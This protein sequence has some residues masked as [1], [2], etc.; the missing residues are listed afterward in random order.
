L[1]GVPAGFADG[2]DNDTTY[3]AGTGLTLSGGQFSLDVPYR[4]PQSCANGQVPK[5]WNGLLWACATDNDTTYTAG[6]GLYLNATQFNLS[7]SYR[8]PQSCAN[9]QLPK[10]NGSAWACA[11]DSSGNGDITAVNAGA[12]LTG[13]GTSGDVTLSADTD[14]LQ[15]RVIGVCPPGNYLKAI[16]AD[17][18]VVCES[19][20][21]SYTEAQCNFGIGTDDGTCTVSCEPGYFITGGGCYSLPYATITLNASHNLGSTKWFCRYFFAVPVEEWFIKARAICLQIP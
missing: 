8:L 19:A 12:G 3:T 7:N 11:D 2:V 6:T 13:G 4:L 20:S 5:W 21:F 18:S 10:W 9:G 17:G 14:V 1:S 15:R 16:N